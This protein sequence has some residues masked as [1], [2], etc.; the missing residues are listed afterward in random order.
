LIPVVS[1]IATLISFGVAFSAFH[2]LSLWLNLPDLLALMLWALPIAAYLAHCTR[3]PR[4]PLIRVAARIY[5][6]FA[7]VVLAAAG[8]VYLIG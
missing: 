6:G 7:G 2:L 4:Q 8:L 1:Y 5:G 3:D